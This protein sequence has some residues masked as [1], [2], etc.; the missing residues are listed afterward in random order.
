MSSLFTPRLFTIGFT[1]FIA[2]GFLSGCKKD[3]P[4]ALPIGPQT[5]TGALSPVDISLTRRGTDVLRQNGRDVYYVESSAVNLRPYEGMDVIIDGTIEANSDPKELPVLVATK[6][7][8]IEQPSHPWTVPALKLT[9][10]APL[11]WN[12]D[13]FD[14]GISFSE[15]GS[16]TPLLTM[17]K[18]SLSILPT[19]TPLVI[20]GQRAVRVTTGSGT[21]V[22]IQNG[23][24]IIAVTIDKTLNDSARKEPVQSVLQLL[25]T[26]VFTSSASSVT[27]GSGS[28]SGTPCGGPAGI[29][30]EPGSYCAVTDT[31]IGS[32]VCRPLSGR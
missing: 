23:P 21:V 25:K 5:L 13:V 30:C 19:G 2:L 26:I 32:G 16:T 3:V 9:F 29:L 31:T 14:D 1:I 12:G 20:G 6:V 17:Y 4:P 11:T 24:H 10:S 15:T 22:Y 28:L 8:R 18:S 27:S 7:T